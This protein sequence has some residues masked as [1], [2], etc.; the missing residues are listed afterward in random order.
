MCGLHAQI[1]NFKYINF[2]KS[3]VW[4][5]MKEWSDATIAVKYQKGSSAV[6]LIIH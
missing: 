6:Y 1:S 2:F 4:L 3:S 5:F